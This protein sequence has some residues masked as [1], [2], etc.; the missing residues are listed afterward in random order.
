MKT[1]PVLPRISQAALGSS[2]ALE[3]V[4]LWIAAHPLRA[5]SLSADEVG[6]QSGASLAAVNRFSR[7]AGFDGFGH[8]KAALAE[9]LQEAA[10]PIQKLQSSDGAG[11]RKGGGD[12]PLAVAQRNLQLAAQAL[13]EKVLDKAAR[14]LLK[15]E[16]VY[17]LGFGMSSYLAQIAAHLLMP[18]GPT[19]IH[20][21]SEGGTEAAARRM[22]RIGRSDMLLAISLPRYSRDAVELARYARERGAWVLAITDRFGAPLVA[23]ADAA[24]LAPAE[25]GV[26]SSSAVAAVA[27]V[28][29]LAA[30]VMQLNPD[31]VRLATELS[32]AVLGHLSVGRPQPFL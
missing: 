10:Q 22:T 31:S 14:R 17:T 18:Y 11:P 28:E 20:L 7:S 1:V 2:P 15:S 3:R 13:D 5:I 27:A 12:H 29:A 32:E 26:L 8:L 9:E 23:Q 30:R 4:G 25:H 16:K 24:L 19:V 21:S 6:Q